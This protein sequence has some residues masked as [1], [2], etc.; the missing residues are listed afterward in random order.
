M[1]MRI[2]IAAVLTA[3]LSAPSS[4]VFAQPVSTAEQWHAFAGKLPV[5]SFVSVRLADGTRFK[6]TLVGVADAELAVQPR[7]RIP[8]ALRTVPFA[9]IAEI[10][11]QKRP[12][13]A[14]R[15]VVTGVAVGAGVYMALVI[16]LLAAGF[17]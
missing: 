8:V 13:S 11:P 3:L 6:G 5:G 12:M 2:V 1:S 16:A 17:D 7:T 4:A 14:G 10:E 9:D 15:K